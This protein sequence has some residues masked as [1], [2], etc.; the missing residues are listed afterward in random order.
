MRIGHFVDVDPERL[1]KAHLMGW[2]F[3]LKP[4][5]LRPRSVDSHTIVNLLV[6]TSHLEAPGRHQRHL[7]FIDRL[8]HRFPL[9][10]GG[11]PCF[12]NLPGLF[13]Q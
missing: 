1:F 9:V 8:N 2:L 3:V 4:T 12:G 5:A 7:H 10:V 6:S 11:Y 13:I